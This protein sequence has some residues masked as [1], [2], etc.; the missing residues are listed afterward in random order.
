MLKAPC[1]Y[2]NMIK[3][4]I[5][6]AMALARMELEGSLLFRREGLET[7]LEDVFAE[8]SMLC[9][10][11]YAY[12]RWLWEKLML[13]V[14]A[15]IFSSHSLLSIMAHDKPY[16]RRN[17]C[18]NYCI[19]GTQLWVLHKVVPPEIFILWIS[20][21]HLHNFGGVFDQATSEFCPKSTTLTVG[22]SP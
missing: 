2:P 12:L 16:E 10:G 21:K 9:S 13:I 1:T 7:G 19:L 15:K 18:I 4:W 8:Q 20:E 14:K 5:I 6:Q 17:S 22:A 11:Q 3:K